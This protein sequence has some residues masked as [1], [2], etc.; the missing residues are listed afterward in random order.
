M[1]V[2]LVRPGPLERTAKPSGL[3]T[4][5]PLD[6]EYT[7]TQIEQFGHCVTVVDLVFEKMDIEFLVRVH[8]PQIVLFSSGPALGNLGR[9]PVSPHAPSSVTHTLAARVKAVNPAIIT[10]VSGD[11]DDSGP[12]Q[13]CHV[14]IDHVVGANRPEPLIAL[15]NGET[16]PATGTR[17]LACAPAFP[18]RQKTTRYRRHYHAVFHRRCAAVA[19]SRHCPTDCDFQP[20]PLVTAGP[21]EPARKPA[22]FTPDPP[23]T[24][25]RSR[26][27]ELD[28]VVEE[29]DRIKERNIVLI[30]DDFLADRARVEAFCQL[31]AD[32]GLRR[33]F[34]VF[35]RAETIAR[36]P[37]TIARLKSVGL[38]AVFVDVEPF[39]P[40]GP[41]ARG[42]GAPV[43]LN[44]RALAVLDAQGIVA[45]G[46][47]AVPPDWT[48]GD[49]R[50]LTA[51]LRPFA[52]LVVSLRPSAPSPATRRADE[53]ADKSPVAGPPSNPPPRPDTEGG[54]PP[55]NP[56]PRFA[57]GVVDHHGGE[58]SLVDRSAEI[59]GS[60]LPLNLRPR[61]HVAALRR[62][63]LRSWAR[64]LRALLGRGGS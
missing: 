7:A 44:R 52:C 33:N 6:L 23:V 2:L 31:V 24:N 27:R 17:P 21:E 26:C 43:D 61:V 42:Q 59:P 63:G 1:N 29:I 50:R 28:D 19:L 25:N 10:V 4:Y 48:R 34:L 39:R 53:P 30:D 60:F 55:S 9:D 56:P 22:G 32:Q 49:S 58:R 57:R 13:D 35:G 40:T 51:Q 14:H 15:V 3:V 64:V 47:F 54:R 62:F 37:G 38:S 18:T 8:R 20:C 46:R 12:G 5:E 41:Q 45:Y 16:P 11:H 36:Q